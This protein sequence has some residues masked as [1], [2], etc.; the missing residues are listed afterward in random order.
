MTKLRIKGGWEEV[1]GRDVWAEPASSVPPTLLGA[2]ICLGLSEHAPLSR[3]LAVPS[4]R[5]RKVKL[6]LLPLP[7]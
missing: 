7:Q 6:K 3:E 2:A 4:V 1:M 5:G